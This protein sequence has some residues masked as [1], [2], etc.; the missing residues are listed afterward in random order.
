M[1]ET[2]V[3]SLGRE[4]SWRRE[5]LTHSRILAWRIP[6]GRKES[7]VTEQLTL[8]VGSVWTEKDKCL[9]SDKHFKYFLNDEMN[10]GMVG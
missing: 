10:R 6:W 7:D 4:D 8:C 3:L 9:T 1:Q 5:R 2:W